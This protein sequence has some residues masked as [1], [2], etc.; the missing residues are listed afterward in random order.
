[1]SAIRG[2]ENSLWQTGYGT[3]KSEVLALERALLECLERIFTPLPQT[4]FQYEEGKIFF[5]KENSEAVLP[6]HLFASAA[7]KF[8][9][10][11]LYRAFLEGAERVSVSK[12]LSTGKFNREFEQLH[13]GT[14]F[15]EVSLFPK[16][17][18]IA[19]LSEFNTPSGEGQ[20]FGFGA[21]ANLNR[22][23]NKAQSELFQTK[24]IS[25]YLSN[26]VVPHIP[27]SRYHLKPTSKLIGAMGWKKTCV[28]GVSV[29]ALFSTR[30]EY[31]YEKYI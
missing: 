22:A 16:V 2:R 15:L 27:L 4:R 21:S 30:N 11:T 29:C 18:I 31:R 9:S 12:F 1:M 3:A 8:G 26:E 6:G 14:R 10:M 25:K 13:N 28:K 23:Y 20:H 19:A 5:S 17:F 24:T 7:G